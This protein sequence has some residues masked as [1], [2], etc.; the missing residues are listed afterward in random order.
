MDSLNDEIENFTV[1]WSN[2]TGKPSTYP[3]STHTHD[4]RYYKK[5]ET[6]NRYSYKDHN[7]DSS[8]SFRD[9]NHDD[10]YFTESE[11][12]EKL[13]GTWVNGPLV[14]DDNW[15]NDIYSQLSCSACVCSII[16]GVLIKQD[17][18]NDNDCHFAYLSHPYIPY[19]PATTIYFLSIYNG[20]GNAV[21]CE[22]NTEGTLRIMGDNANI[23]K[24]GHWVTGG[25]TYIV[26]NAK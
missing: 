16:F 3:P 4:D 18:V 11:I 21:L 19:R 5:D 1:S 26:S 23:V 15:T 6:D 14:K 2:I 9:H 22:I 24:G 13:S 12:L 20:T 7:H 8:Y 10:R 25:V 17:I